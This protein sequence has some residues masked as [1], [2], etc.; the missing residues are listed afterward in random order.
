MTLLENRFQAILKTNP[1]FT[2]YTAFAHAILSIKVAPTTVVKVF[3]QL[4]D[5]KDYLPSERVDILKHLVKI[6]V[7]A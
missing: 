1:N 5:K 7:Q 3:D 2:T 4:V 6:A